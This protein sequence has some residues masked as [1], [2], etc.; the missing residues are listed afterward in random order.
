MTT[1]YDA[2]T[3]RLEAHGSTRSGSNW[4]CPGHPDDTPSLSVTAADGSALIYCHGSCGTDTERILAPLD[5]P[6]AALFDVYWNGDGNGHRP[7]SDVGE[8]VA[9]LAHHWRIPEEWLRE[10][11][12]FR[13]DDS[14]DVPFVR[15]PVVSAEADRVLFAR[16]R[17]G[18]ARENGYRPRF[19][20]PADVPLS[21][22][23]MENLARARDL[24]YV[25]LTEGEHDAITLLY[26]GEPAVGTLGANGWKSDL[27]TFL[28][29][30]ATVYVVPDADESGERFARAVA[31]SLGERV[32]IVR[33]PTGA[34]D[35]SDVYVRDPATFAWWI[36]QGK[37]DAAEAH[38]SWAERYVRVDLG[39]IMRDGVEPPEML[40]EGWLV[41]GEHHTFFGAKESAK[42]W[43]A[44]HC[45][46]SLIREGKT[47][48]WV[49]LEMGRRAMAER[50]AFFGVSPEQVSEHFVFLEFPFF[51][52][53]E[54][55]RADW[56]AIVHEVR[57]A[58]VVWDAQTGAL[59]AADVQENLGTDVAK[60]QRAYVEPVR[61]VGG[62]PLM[63]DHTGH[64][65]Q[66]RA[67]ASRQKGAAAKVEISFRVK[68]DEKPGRDRMG[69]VTVKRTKNTLDAP[70]PEERRFRV[71]SEDGRFVI[72]D[73]TDAAVE[74]ADSRD[75]QRRM[76]L[77]DRI[78]AVLR[79]NPGKRLTGRALE[80]LV[81]GRGAEIRDAAKQ[82]ALDPNSPVEHAPGSRGSVEYWVDPAPPE[83]TA[84]GG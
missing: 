57:P 66:S 38:P 45:A 35:V 13:D 24:G 71:G 14:E 10:N 41:R 43:F 82:L 68:E 80:R 42:T 31:S 84:S 30:I 76:E 7:P 46:A 23:G 53:A 77:C 54:G 19:D 8:S 27:A 56:A 69:Y 21:L 5:L 72:E 70:I 6:T 83:A 26:A 4:T 2:V 15:Y 52:M 18:F 75:A 79:L 29:G 1:A 34:K 51:S 81:E 47:V 74:A 40:I 60:W 59:A 48:L 16:R 25:W 55:D 63:I 64:D 58:L 32:R 61:R 20:Q 50:L 36:A 28:D 49:D 73:V 11:R 37:A 44:L 3:A 67:V 33:L 12:G 22:Y 78:T 39:E 65:D 17:P 9:L 62:T